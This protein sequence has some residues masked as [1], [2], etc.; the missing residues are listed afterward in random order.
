MAVSKRL[1]FEIL[2]RDNHT[3][4]Y[5]G[6]SAPDV[7]LTVDH[8][9]PEALGGSDDPSN[10]VAACDACNS[11][12]SSIVPGSPVVDDVKQDALRWA[13]A[14]EIARIG[15]KVQRDERDEGREVFRGAWV[16]W[17]FTPFNGKP[18]TFDLPTEWPDT[19]DS[20]YK[21]GLDAEDLTEAI[22]VTMRRRKVDDRF[23]YFCGVAWNMLRARQ[24]MA[25]V[26]APFVSLD[27]E[28]T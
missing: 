12:K 20:M 2:R 19:V 4:R 11:G 17:S 26:L 1:R 21:A 23:R 28:T 22:G 5:C 14:M 6:A 15:D 3:C 10:L 25:Q 9:V 24:E 27:D 13:R 16:E 18:Q 7:K 8:V